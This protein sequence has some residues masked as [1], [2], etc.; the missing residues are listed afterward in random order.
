MVALDP[1]TRAQNLAAPSPSLPGPLSASDTGGFSF[2]DLLNIV[3]PL[4]HLPV[5]STIYRAITG[6]TIKPF[7]KIAG[8]TLYGGVIGFVS[9]LADTIFEKITGKDFGDTVLSLF[10]GSHDS[11]PTA[12]A[13]ASEPAIQV[14]TQTNIASPDLTALVTSMSRNGIDPSLAKRAV[15][16]YRRAIDLTQHPLTP[17]A[18]AQPLS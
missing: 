2:H 15:S 12:V 10:T 13:Q 7:D 6:D 5:I 18:A 16:A 4:Q 17:S 9:S 1:T 11:K 8:D 14:S 3:N